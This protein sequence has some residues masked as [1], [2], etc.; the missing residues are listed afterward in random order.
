M[1][2]LDRCLAAKAIADDEVGGAGLDEM[3]RLIFA[4]ALFDAAGGVNASD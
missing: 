2:D 4:K 3:D 1:F